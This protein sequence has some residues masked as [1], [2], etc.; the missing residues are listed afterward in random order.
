MKL[1]VPTNRVR[2]SRFVWGRY[3]QSLQDWAFGGTRTQGIHLRWLPWARVEIPFRDCPCGTASRSANPTRRNGHSRPKP[4]SQPHPTPTD[5][6]C[7]RG[8]A[9]PAPH[10]HNVR[11]SGSTPNPPRHPSAAAPICNRTHRRRHSFTTAPNRHN[12]ESAAPRIGDDTYSPQRCPTTSPI[13]RHPPVPNST[14][15]VRSL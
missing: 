15:I 6:P 13:G 1:I 7:G 8:L 9:A 4:T 14:S 5:T 10:I 12:A 2:R 3:R 11:P